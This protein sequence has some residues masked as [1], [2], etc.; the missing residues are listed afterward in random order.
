MGCFSLV[1][2]L[3]RTS[4]DS[5]DSHDHHSNYC[6]NDGC[7]LPSEAS[8]SVVVVEPP[9]GE[10]CCCLAGNREDLLLCATQR[11]ARDLL[12]TFHMPLKSPFELVA[13]HGCGCATL[14]RP[15]RHRLQVRALLAPRF[16]AR[17]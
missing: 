13:L 1:R 16:P 15:W 14:W 6:V 4:S 2:S 9:P 5:T 7:I 10:G 8:L 12:V 11:P 3:L 17:L